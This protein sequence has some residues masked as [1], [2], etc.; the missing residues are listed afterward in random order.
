MRL[1]L[2]L[3]TQPYSA[4]WCG[5]TICP[6]MHPRLLAHSAGTQQALCLSLEIDM[7]M[8]TLKPA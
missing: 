6:T 2:T 3:W 1:Y 5:C 8:Q 4:H 7:F